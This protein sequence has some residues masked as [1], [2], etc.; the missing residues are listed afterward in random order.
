MAEGLAESG[1]TVVLNGRDPKT[2]AER[3]K[4]LT[5][6]KLKADFLAFDVTDEKAARKGVDDVAAKHGQLDI[7]IANAGM[8][9]RRPIAE[10]TAA[11]WNQIITADLT[12]CFLM[13]QQAVKHMRTRKH[14]RIIYTTSLTALRGRPGIHAYVAAKTGLVGMTRSLAA[15]LA[16]DGITVN[17]VL[18]GYF[19]TELNKA[20]LDDPA[21][22]DFVN[23]RTPMKRWGEPRELAGA[24]IYLASEAGSFVTGQQIIVDG[25]MSSM[26]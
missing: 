5:D 13:T 14:G 9:F 17:G 11:E 18:P 24:A 20:L 2:L 7:L 21:F 25:G 3:V 15:E 1:A 22:V 19:K 23:G 8:T 12:S 10:W 6:R 16:P 4:S 26:V